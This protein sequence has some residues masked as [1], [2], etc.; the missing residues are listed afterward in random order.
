MNRKRVSAIIILEGKILLIHRRRNDEE[1]FVFPG[2]GVENGEDL[3]QALSREVKEELSLWV[4][5]ARL[6]FELDNQGQH[7][8]FF[9]IDKFLG[10]PKLGGPEL[11]RNNRN[12]MYEP[13]WVELNKLVSLNLYPELGKEKLI[14]ILPINKS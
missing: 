12:N 5:G 9:L 8:T 1:Y 2:G 14:Q 13:I 7:E 3:Q 4:Q 6:L 10:E 11:E